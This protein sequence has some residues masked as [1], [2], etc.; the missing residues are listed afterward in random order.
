MKEEWR[1]EETQNTLFSQDR[2]Q[3]HICQ[4]DITSS[5][6]ARFQR[7]LTPLVLR[8]IFF[9]AERIVDERF[10]SKCHH[11]IVIIIIIVESRLC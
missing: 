11:L 5:A 4:T 9:S 8:Q 7:G 3:R 2:I 10:L 1:E 6:G